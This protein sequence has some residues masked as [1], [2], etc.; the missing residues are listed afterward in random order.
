M[1]VTQGATWLQM[2]TT[3][4]LH[5][6]ARNVAQISA[7]LTAVCFALAGFWAQSIEGFVITSQIVTDA[8]S[9]PLNKEVV[10]DGCIV[11]QLRSLPSS[12][13]CAFVGCCDASAGCTGF[14]L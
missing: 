4:A 7:V 12:M 9:N 8:V 3:D 13:G 14:A 1:I 11:Q 6:R 5:V 10:T 2:K